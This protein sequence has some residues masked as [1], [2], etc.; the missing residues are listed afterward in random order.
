M[1]SIPKTSRIP[2]TRLYPHKYRSTLA[3]NMINKGAPAE[4]VQGILGHSNVNTTLKSYC[5]I[6]K[7][8]YK[9]THKQFS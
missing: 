5:K 6:D 1:W 2:K 9:R 4:H 7:E 8:S 3:T